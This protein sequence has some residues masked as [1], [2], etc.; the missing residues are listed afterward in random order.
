MARVAKRKLTEQH[1]EKL[2]A[3]LY[4][5]IGALRVTQAELFLSELLGVEEKIMIA[6][7]LAIIVMIHEKHSLYR[8]AQTLSV[9][10]ATAE[11]IKRRLTAGEYTNIIKL[12]KKNKTGYISIL[13]TIDSILHVGGI[14]PH[15][16]GKDRLKNLSID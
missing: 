6:K 16:S 5:T 3:Q 14:L 12:L 2:F 4:T 10:S 13:E 8:V 7:R 1:L 15:Y 11:K 9:S